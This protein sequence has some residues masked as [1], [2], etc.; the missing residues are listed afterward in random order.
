MP[1]YE[2]HLNM[3][4]LVL[5]IL[6][7]LSTPSFLAWMAQ[8]YFGLQNAHAHMNHGIVGAIFLGLLFIAL[9][10][11]PVLPAFEHSFDRTG[12]HVVAAEPAPKQSAALA[13]MKSSARTS[14]K[15]PSG[16]VNR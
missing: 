2:V 16:W 1:N 10:K 14:S 4:Q 11:S 6:V 15:K 3:V 7:L 9:Y 8:H 13:S 12:S 5:L